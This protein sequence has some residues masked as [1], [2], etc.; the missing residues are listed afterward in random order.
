[1][2]WVPLALVLA[3]VVAGAPPDAPNHIR[4]SL[5]LVLL[6]DVYDTTF[7]VGSKQRCDP[8]C[9]PDPGDREECAK[10]LNNDDVTRFGL[11]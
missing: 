5:P 7:L 11:G 2:T 4:S 9:S 3:L 6:V 8:S 10:D 1:M